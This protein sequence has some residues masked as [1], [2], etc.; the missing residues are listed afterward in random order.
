MGSKMT[1]PE[2]TSKRDP[3][4]N[5]LGILGDG[6]DKYITDM[7]AAGQRQ[8]VASSVLPRDK[9]AQSSSAATPPRSSTSPVT[10]S[11]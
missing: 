11:P 3:H 1:V 7:E 9:G 5:A 10:A 2:D 6:Q 4:L 8:L